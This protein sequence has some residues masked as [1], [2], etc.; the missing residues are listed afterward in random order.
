MEWMVKWPEMKLE[1]PAKTQSWRNV[2]AM[3]RSLVFILE[4][5]E[6]E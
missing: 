6:T 4:S 3:L 1:R 5:I 2:D